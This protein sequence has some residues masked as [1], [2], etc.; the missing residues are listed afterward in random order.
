[1]NDPATPSSDLQ[2]VIAST[3]SDFPFR[4][5][6]NLAPLVDF[7]TKEMP[8]AHPIKGVL[9]RLVEEELRKAPELLEPIADLGVVDRHRELIDMLMAVVFAPA[10][11]D[12]AYGAA[13]IP[14]HLRTF[15][16]TPAFER[17][18]AGE[19]GFLRGRVNTDLSTAAT[20]RLRYAYAL[21][22]RRVYGVEVKLEVPIVFT[23]A[24]P[25]TGLDRHFKMSFDWR[26]V[27]VVPVGGVP[28][29]G[30][31]E[32]V[33][34]QLAEPRALLALLPPDRF[35]FRGFTVLRAVEVTDQEVLSSLKRDLIDKESIISTA[36]FQGLQDKLR[37]LFRRPR[38]RLG[39]AAVEGEQVLM[40]NSGARGEHGCIFSDSAHHTVAE[41]AGSIYD[42]AARAGEP[43]LIEDLAAMPDRTPVDEEILCTGVR[44][45]VVA[46]LYYQDE[47][48]GMLELGSPDPGDLGPL[49]LPKAQEVLP[50]FTMAVNRSMEELEARIQA[51]IKEKCTAIHPSVEW[52]FRQAVLNGIERQRI[53]TATALEMEPIVFEDVYPL[54]GLSDLRGSSVHRAAAIQADLLAQLGLAR[55]VLRAAHQARPLPA[56]DELG[57]RTEQ[58]RAEI[59]TSLRSGDEIA[60]IGFLRRDVESLFDHL[61]AFGSDVHA[62]I[63]AYRAALEP[64]LG[65]VYQRRKAFEDSVTLLNEA[66]SSYLDLEEQAAQTMFPHYFEKQKTDGVDYSIYVGGSLTENGR[67]HPLYLRSLRLWQLMVACGI[68]IRADRLRSRLAVPL[69]TT[70]LILVQHMPLAIRFRPDEKRFD[71]D[72]AYNVRY[73]IIKKRIDKAIVRGRTERLT[74]P[75][76]LAIVYAQNGE[77]AEYRG[78]IEY[79]QHRRYLGPE[80]EDLELEELQGVQG[81]RALRVAVELDNP[82]L[83]VTVPLGEVER[84]V[85]LLPGGPGLP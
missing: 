82:R 79:L 83:D 20:V 34:T 26:F 51:F 4:V 17:M 54:Y 78:Y 32:R 30:D 65:T 12:Q 71:V 72:G 2:S 53:G 38:L 69:E 24:C 27:D 29:L 66:I 16:P 67:F 1:M 57:Y 3:P 49:D 9:G 40:L 44:N 56:L 43:L 15:Y 77:A 84:A 81:L 63:D 36:R 25:E 68:A 48:I 58:C 59:E 46:P 64:R 55:D 13:M 76:K 18:L 21:I 23:V 10:W 33:L 31:R 62:A 19:G 61:G 28:P 85:G 74:Q 75:G 11:R 73:E 8:R 52:R 39:L 35:V 50:L 45:V 6:L 60:V 14:F 7:W 41:F 5:E 80:V 47:L 42:R 70:N 37:T 22:L